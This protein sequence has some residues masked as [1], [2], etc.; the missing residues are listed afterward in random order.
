MTA[1]TAQFV[2]I[3]KIIKP[4]G[5]KGHV[6]VHSLT[7][8]PGRFEGLSEVTVVPP[9]APP[10]VTAVNSVR[11]DRMSYVVG[12]EA[13]TTPEEA[14]V[15]RGALLTIPETETPPLSGGRYY[16]FQLLG[17]PVQDESGRP[18]G[19]LEE[20]IET[21]GNAVFAVR[22]EGGEVLIPAARSAIASVDVGGRLIV[23]RRAAI[24]ED[25][26]EV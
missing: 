12:F 2:T 18:L 13:F 1:D 4:F 6:R 9:S 15:C 17:L 24:V 22:G 16:Q 11:K 25:R 23:V 21:P 20:I 8:V 10:F 3:G 5:L 26:D 14:A 19:T 7:D